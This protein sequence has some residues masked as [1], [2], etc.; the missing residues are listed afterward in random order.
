[1]NNSANPRHLHAARSQHMASQHMAT[2]YRGSANPRYLHATRSQHGST[3]HRNKATAK[4]D[5]RA[6]LGNVLFAIA[7]FLFSLSFVSALSGLSIFD[8]LGLSPL[9]APIT[10]ASSTPVSDWKK[11][12]M[13][14]L[15]QT[16]DA[17]SGSPY[18]G[19]TM[20]THGCGPTA[21]S[22][23]YVFLTGR[24][25]MDPATMARFSEKNGYVDSNSTSWAFMSKGAQ[26]LGL[27]AR[28]LPAD[29]VSIVSQLK[30]GH[31]VICIVG[32]GDFTSEG[33]FIVITGINDDGTVEVRDPNSEERSHRMWELDRVLGQCRNLWTYSI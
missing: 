3:T 4:V 29:K 26:A 32:P 20:S 14:Y 8:H 11:G 5:E 28:E 2:A 27:K 19:A 18:A 1:M 33:H 7:F 6:H 22:M 25:D 24:T 31:P 10:T 30:M 23:V 16:D 13:P 21:M 15:Y 17:W 12:S 9:R